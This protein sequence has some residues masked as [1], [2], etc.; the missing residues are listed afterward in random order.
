MCLVGEDASG[1]TRLLKDWAEQ[2]GAG[3]V[4]GADLAR[5]DIGEISGLSVS[6]L[7]VDDADQTVPGAG[8][9]AALNLCRDR[10]AVIALAGKSDPSSWK[11]SIPDL[12]SRLS[13]IPVV[14]I[15]APNEET[16][17]TRL[18][19]AC[20]ERFM[21]LPEETAKYLAHRMERSYVKIDQVVLAMEKNAKG[22]ALTKVTARNALDTLSN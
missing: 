11:A 12:Q 6:A 16:L 4:A 17:Q 1:K 18:I 15:D 3:V 9:L 14:H 5:A 8:L 13:A 21:K 7:V 22:K 2:I 20:R 10:G 19:A